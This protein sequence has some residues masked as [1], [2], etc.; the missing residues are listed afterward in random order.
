MLL[1]KPEHNIDEILYTMS[2]P[3]ISSDPLLWDSILPHEKVTADDRLIMF[4][5]RGDVLIPSGEKPFSFHII[6]QI[7]H[8][9]F[10]IYSVIILIHTES[11]VGE[12]RM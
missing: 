6:N 11:F 7:L 8:K 2:L 10:Q 1:K 12:S 9:I 5:D 4:K 3:A